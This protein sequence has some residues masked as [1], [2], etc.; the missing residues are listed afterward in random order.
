MQNWGRDPGQG[1]H[2]RPQISS[3][4]M[5]PFSRQ[6]EEGRL[7]VPGRGAG[8]EG[9]DWVRKGKGS[10]STNWPSQ[11]SHST[12]NIVTNIVLTMYGAR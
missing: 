6:E 11:K 3:Y 7:M 12:G 5:G 4:H 1:L 10:R 2:L 8:F 9:G